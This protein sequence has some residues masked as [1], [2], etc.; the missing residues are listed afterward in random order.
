[1]HPISRNKVRVLADNVAFQGDLATINRY[2]IILEVTE[3]ND[4]LISS[5]KDL[6]VTQVDGDPDFPNKFF[7]E[8]TRFKSYKVFLIRYN[9]VN[10]SGSTIQMKEELRLEFV[11]E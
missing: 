3:N 4:V 6:K 9:Y 5:Y 8:R 1:M 11:E 2:G 10:D 7:I